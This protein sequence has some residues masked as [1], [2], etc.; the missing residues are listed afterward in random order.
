MSAMPPRK[1]AR[2]DAEAVRS[3]GA[4]H[5][6]GASSKPPSAELQ[7]PVAGMAVCKGRRET[8]RALKGQPKGKAKAAA[9]SKATAEEKVLQSPVPVA[10]TRTLQMFFGSSKT[11]SAARSPAAPM[12]GGESQLV[13]AADL[14]D[15]PCNEPSQLLVAGS[16]AASIQG[17]ESQL[18]AAADLP[19]AACTES[20]QLD[21]GEEK[22]ASCEGPQLVA[23]GSLVA[24]L[25]DAE[26]PSGIDDGAD[27]DADV[28]D[29]LA[30]IIA[31]DGHLPVAEAATQE[32]DVDDM[33]ATPTL[34]VAAAA[35]SSSGP[36]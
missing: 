10:P 28:L 32:G 22:A 34:G 21:D 11:S 12:E 33:Q 29:A 36:T 35:A 8:K 3:D 13:A 23:A 20:S 14:P 18:V 31:E 17:E 30:D 6:K 9:K 7:Q 16:L 1:K 25:D 24:Q 15:A 4:A 2:S 19:A 27:T 26:G 5:T